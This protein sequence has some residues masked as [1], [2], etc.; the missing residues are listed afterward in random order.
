MLSRN[1]KSEKQNLSLKSVSNT[2]A[3]GTRP[4]ISQ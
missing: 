2:E 3:W 4:E 1:I